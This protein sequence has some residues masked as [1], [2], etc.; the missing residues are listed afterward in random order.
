MRRS[1]AWFA[2]LALT[3]TTAFCQATPPVELLNTLNEPAPLSGH[4]FLKTNQWIAT[5][6]IT[7]DRHYLLDHFVFNTRG[8][9]EVTDIVGSVLASDGPGGVPGTLLSPLVVPAMPFSGV[10][11]ESPPYVPETEVMLEPNTAYWVFLGRVDGGGTNPVWLRSEEELFS[12]FAPFPGELE[13]EVPGVGTIG[14]R[15]AVSRN[16]GATWN[17]LSTVYPQQL[18]VVA[19]VIPEPSAGALALLFASIVGL[20]LRKWGVYLAPVQ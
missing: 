18:K 2:F 4:P 8:R 5:Q 12:P 9:S 3:A 1:A 16:R 15:P 14:P 10:A 19:T 7:D 13:R 17:I 6:F 11:A 20:R